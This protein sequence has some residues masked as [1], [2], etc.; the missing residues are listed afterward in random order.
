[1]K[2]GNDMTLVKAEMSFYHDAVGT[3]ALGEVFEI[4]NSQV[5]AEL[6][7]AG[8]V[9]QVDGAEAQAHQDSQKLQ[10]EMGEKQALTNEAVS[11]A[12]HTQNQETL[13]HQQKID[14][15]RQQ[16]QQQQAQ[17]QQSQAQQSQTQQAS[18]VQ[19]KANVKKA[20]K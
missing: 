9:K 10:Q 16:Q 19:H 7:Q 18:E 20:D 8:Y 12:H 11:L 5:C 13:Q 4:K 6:E 2:G 14:Q 15:L 1:M 17:S 3:K